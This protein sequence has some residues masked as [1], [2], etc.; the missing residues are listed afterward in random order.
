MVL[1]HQ[2][3]CQGVPRSILRKTSSIRCSVITMWSQEEN[4]WYA[5]PLSEIQVAHELLIKCWHD[6]F[7]VA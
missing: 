2:D 3:H 1:G 6:L 4:A 7:N 5:S